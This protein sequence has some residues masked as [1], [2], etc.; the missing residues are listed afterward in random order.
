VSY[1]YTINIWS[2]DSGACELRMNMGSYES[3][4]AQLKDGPI[5]SRGSI[6]IFNLTTG[7]C[8]MGMTVEL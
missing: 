8:D 3:S 5:C 4:V 1:D 7:V 2:R 6:K